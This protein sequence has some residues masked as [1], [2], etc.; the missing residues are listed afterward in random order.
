MLKIEGKWSIET[1]KQRMEGGGSCETTEKVRVLSKENGRRIIEAIVLTDTDT[2]RSGNI[3]VNRG[4]GYHYV[5]LMDGKKQLSF[6]IDF[7]KAGLGWRVLSN[8]G[9]SFVQDV[10]T[11]MAAV[12]LLPAASKAEVKEI[13]IQ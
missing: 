8:N 5:S 13:R 2:D 6:A 10:K 9:L 7:R 12:E 3:S 4:K 1:R 11:R